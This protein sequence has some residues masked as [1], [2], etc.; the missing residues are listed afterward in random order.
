MGAENIM[1]KGLD[2]EVPGGRTRNFRLGMKAQAWLAKKHGTIKRVYAK[3][4]GE[5]DSDN[6]PVDKA[7]DGDMSECQ[8]EALVD[9]VYAG[10]LRDSEKAGE[11]FSRD[12][13]LNL[14]DEI[15]IE[16]FFALISG[17]TKASLP[18]SGEEDPTPGQT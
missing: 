9:V 16:P 4:S 18:E 12:D 13:A 5:I 11:V 3:L 17:E 10:L 14:I 1:W 8:L 7:S 2:L 6:K 15:G